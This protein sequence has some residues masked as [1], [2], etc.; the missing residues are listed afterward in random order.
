MAK[1]KDTGTVVIYVNWGNEACV[2]VAGI[3][4]SET[5]LQVSV[6]TILCRFALWTYLPAE[7]QLQRTFVR[8]DEIGVSV[9]CRVNRSGRFEI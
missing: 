3:A 9:Y 8:V 2:H 7:A 1:L 4:V 6:F 5:I